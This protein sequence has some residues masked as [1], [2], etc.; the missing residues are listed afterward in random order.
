MYL[1]CAIVGDAVKL[2]TVTCDHENA[3]DHQ[4]DDL[5]RFS[6]SLCCCACVDWINPAGGD[7][8]VGANWSTGMMPGTADVARFNLAFAGYSVSFS[9]EGAAG[10]Y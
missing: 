6:R 9:S 4:I 5:R 1:V 2:T 8:V 3:R 10:W 7:F